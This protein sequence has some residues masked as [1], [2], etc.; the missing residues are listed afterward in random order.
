[1]KKVIIIIAAIVV[2]AI[3]FKACSGSASDTAEETTAE[4]QETATETSATEDTT[5]ATSGQESQESDEPQEGAPLFDVTSENF[6]NTYTD[7]R[8]A[9]DYNGDSC[10]IIYSDY[11][12][13]SDESNS[14]AFS[15]A[16]VSAFQNGVELET[17]FLPSDDSDPAENNLSKDIQPGITINAARVFKLEDM[18]DVSLECKDIM[19]FD[20][21]ATQKATIKLQ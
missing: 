2:I 9:T 19:N 15:Y 5:E 13:L 12:N 21:S 17:T 3:G 8:V 1:M 6:R 20:S 4:T 14:P 7:Y 10:I 16:I 11:T 18:S